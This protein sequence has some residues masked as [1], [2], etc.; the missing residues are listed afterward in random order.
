VIHRSDVLAFVARL[1]RG[2]FDVAFA[3]PPWSSGL[4]TTL[5]ERWIEKPFASVLGIEHHRDERLPGSDDRRKY[6]DTVIT[7][8]RTD[9]P[10][11]DSAIISAGSDTSQ[12]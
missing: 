6:G 1:G 2:E 9:P 4:A 11:S 12:P 5:A 7:F 10:A 3:D 8:F